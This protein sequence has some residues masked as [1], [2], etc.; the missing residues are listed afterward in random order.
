M[1]M[2]RLTLAAII[3]CAPGALLMHAQTAGA[4]EK[5]SLR[6]KFRKGDRTRMTLNMDMD[7][8]M[9]MPGMDGT[10]DTSGKMTQ[11]IEFVYHVVD[12]LPDKSVKLEMTYDR[13]AQTMDMG[14]MKMSFDSKK[15][16]PSADDP[17]AKMFTAAI[18]PLL[19]L[20]L[21]LV[22]DPQHQV[23]KISGFDA[24][25]EKLAK[26]PALSG[27][28]QLM[29]NSLG[30][31]QLKGMMRQFF[32]HAL[33]SRPV[34]PGES[35]TTNQ[36][37][38]LPMLGNFEIDST[39]TLMSVGKH[40]GK[41]CAQIHMVAQMKSA[42]K[43]PTSAPAGMPE[44]D[45]RKCDVTGWIWFDLDAGHIFESETAQDMEMVM[46]LPSTSQPGAKAKAGAK[47]ATEGK[48]VQKIRGKI[49][50]TTRPEPTTRP[51]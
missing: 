15:D 13:V 25:W 49:R 17:M 31:E 33:P 42:D 30:D 50:M 9:K 2:S 6:Y 27:T 12:V 45:I 23:K 24:Y 34:A 18:K 36:S 1:K 16:T 20:K 48:M 38:G 44:I 40:K 32:S 21:T 26:D 39:F 10:K 51:K 28:R 46:G 22:L 4:A 5:V 8:D 43:K 14:G 11:L 7:M 35:W 19:G 29:R 3:L 47:P 37:M 41:R